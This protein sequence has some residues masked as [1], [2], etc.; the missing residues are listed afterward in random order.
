MRKEDG[1]RKIKEVA[2]LRYTPHESGAPRIVALGKGEIAEK[3]LQAA[4]ENDVPIYNDEK[5]AHTLNQFNLGDE[6]PP[7]LYEVVAEVLV[8]VSSLDRE[9]GEKYGSVGQKGNR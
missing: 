1:N 3:I 9:F 6:I 7:E 5:L 4:R 8:F 2:A